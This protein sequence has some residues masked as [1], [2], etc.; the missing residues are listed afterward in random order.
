MTFHCLC[1]VIEY[2]VVFLCCS[3]SM[4]FQRL[5]SCLGLQIFI[6]SLG[7]PYFAKL[8]ASN[9][10]VRGPFPPCLNSLSKGAKRKDGV[11]S[12]YE[13][14]VLVIPGEMTSHFIKLVYVFSLMVMGSGP[15]FEVL[16]LAMFIAIFPLILQWWQIPLAQVV[17]SFLFPTLLIENLLWRETSS[18]GAV[19]CTRG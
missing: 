10:F 11:L 17:G 2:L 13:Q 15:V 8:S 16:C 1:C 18:R 12:H 14:G 4:G 7:G 3:S 5:N 9:F 19:C 6:Q